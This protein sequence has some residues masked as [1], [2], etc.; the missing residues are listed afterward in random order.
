MDRLKKERSAVRRAFSRIRKTFE[1]EFKNEDRSFDVLQ[2]I[3]V[4]LEHYTMK[5]NELDRKMMDAILDDEK[6]TDEALDEEAEN[7]D[8]Y[9]MIYLTC[10]NN[11]DSVKK[12]IDAAECR[13]SDASQEFGKEGS[14][15]AGR[16]QRLPK[17]ELIKYDGG[18]KGWLQFWGQF[19]KIDEDP[20]IDD[21]DKMQL[22]LMYTVPNSKAR[23][24]IEK[25]LLSGNN[26]NIALRHLKSRCAKDECLVEVYVRESAREEHD[27]EQQTTNLE[28]L[29]NFIK[30]EVDN[31][32]RIQLAHGFTLGKERGSKC[33][34][35][36]SGT[37]NL[38]KSVDWTPITAYSDTLGRVDE[39]YPGRAMQRSRQLLAVTCDPFNG[40]THWKYPWKKVLTF[41]SQQEDLAESSRYPIGFL[42]R[43]V[44]SC[45]LWAG[46]CCGHSTGTPGIL[47]GAI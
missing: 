31:E 18:L 34:Q 41:F 39:L 28:A 6:T 22:L 1:D 5:L 40:S 29:M 36:E 27:G 12:G 45:T 15:G 17:L 23:R 33:K 38:L 8:E 26:Y 35:P 32:E 20:T 24:I 46:G 21:D 7:V 42:H 4:Q 47:C 13:C 30:A 11:F 9:Q 14:L 10:R 16:R 2:P 25:F 37:N 3:F 44:A 43:L 19:R